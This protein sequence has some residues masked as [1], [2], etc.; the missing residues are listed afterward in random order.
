MK[1]ETTLRGQFTQNQV[2]EVGINPNCWYA[3]AWADQLKVGQVMPAMIWQQAV[4]LYRDA[5]GQI[6]ALENVCPHQGV[7]LHHGEV[8]GNC[9]VCPYHGWRFD[10]QGQC[11]HIPYLPAKQKLPRAQ[12]RSYP[13]QEKY[14]LLWIFPGSPELAANYQLPEI[15]EFSDP[16]WLIIPITGHFNVHFSVCNENTIDVFHGYLH[17]NIQGW[18]DP[19]LLS[20]QE[21]EDSVRA[22]Y[23]IRYQG[24]LTKILGLSTSR[25]RVTTRTVS[26]YYRYPNYQN[27]L[28]GVSAFHQM[29]LP[30]GPDKTLSFSLLFLRLGLPMWIVKPLKP[31]IIP[32][33]RRF[34]FMRFLQQ[35]ITMMESAKR[36][37][38]A[39]P[40]RRYVEVNPAIVALQRVIVRQYELFV[41]RSTLLQ[42]HAKGSPPS[43]DS[44]AASAS[45][46]LE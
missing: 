16:T 8:Q 46:S 43:G 26:I 20:L 30:V 21:T 17:R 23:Q 5:Q 4:A 27:T 35:D 29:R 14:G 25:D 6:H 44:L 41:H 22:E 28:E 3:I 31:L 34:L 12:T 13:I 39:S 37:Y 9:L 40:S 7:E 1:L 36:N 24:W 33:L 42:H 32:I 19:A 38:Q 10:E 11:V 18:F 45:L 2:R 15:P